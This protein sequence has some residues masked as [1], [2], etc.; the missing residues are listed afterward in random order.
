MKKPGIGAA[1]RRCAGSCSRLSTWPRWRRNTE[2]YRFPPDGRP[3]SATAAK[4]LSR[5]RPRPSIE[6]PP[7]C[8]RPAKTRHGFPGP[9][10]PT[11][12]Q[13]F[14]K[15]LDTEASASRQA[16]TRRLARSMIATR[17]T[18]RDAG[19]VGAPDV[20][21]P[22]SGPSADR[23]GTV[24]TR[25]VAPA[26]SSAKP[27]DRARRNVPRGTK[28]HPN[29]STK[30]LRWTSICNRPRPVP[31]EKP[32]RKGTRAIRTRA[33]SGTKTHGFRPETDGD[34]DASDLLPAPLPAAPS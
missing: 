6:M 15:R 22:P 3:P 17:K 30:S 4:M 14:L 16:R 8:K 28:S 2:K 20:V 1:I 26:T 5:H 9:R 31:A 29:R 34:H 11:Y 27:N 12:R 13:D 32:Y 24:A 21:G 25:Q 33:G 10:S 7:A 18:H 23:A 19:D